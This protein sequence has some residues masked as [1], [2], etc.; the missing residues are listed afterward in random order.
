MKE[1]E[2][3]IERARKGDEKA[4]KELVLYMKN[5]LYRVAKSRL[6]NDEDIKDVIQNTMIKVFKN[7]KSLKN[8]EAFRIW[9]IR[10]LINECNKF[11]NRNKRRIEIIEREKAKT[12]SVI[13]DYFTDDINDEI[14]FETK[15]KQL[16]QKEQDI[17][18]LSY[19]NNYSC[20]QISKIL[21]MNENTV[22]SSLRRA[23]KKLEKLYMEGDSYEYK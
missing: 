18:V 7:I 17:I 10:I 14:N 9:M 21:N 12:D 13:T 23:R 3:I 22:K 16:N 15:L 5:D 8:I 1:T 6:M 19:G 11:Y 4:F 20:L 2:E